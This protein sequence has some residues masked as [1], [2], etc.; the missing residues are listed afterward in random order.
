MD[1][2]LKC[3]IE[4]FNFFERRTF[5]SRI[6]IY[7]FT[8]W[9][10]YYGVTV[11][12]GPTLVVI[13]TFQQLGMNVGLVCKLTWTMSTNGLSTRVNHSLFHF[14]QL[15]R[16]SLKLLIDLLHRI[17]PSFPLFPFTNHIWWSTPSNN[18]KENKRSVSR[19]NSQNL[20][21]LSHFD[22]S[23]YI[24]AMHCPKIWVMFLGETRR[25]KCHRIHQRCECKHKQHA[26]RILG[27]RIRL[28]K[29]EL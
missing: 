5:F 20:F 13:F 19:P 15:K 12:I 24:I 21:E 29:W 8:W 2:C 10:T 7:F 28:P 14:I 25:N 22:R 3:K 16:A 23:W 11:Y 1:F 26:E 9:R 18:N 6:N 17:L 4:K 27:E